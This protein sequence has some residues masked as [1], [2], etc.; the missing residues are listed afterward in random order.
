MLQNTDGRY[1]NR[2]VKNNINQ[3]QQEWEE[4]IFF[5]FQKMKTEFFPVAD[6]ETVTFNLN[7]L[8]NFQYMQMYALE[9][10]YNSF[11]DPEP[12]D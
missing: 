1:R 10:S 3:E 7:I 4:G 2:S 12:T 11:S 8:Y 9:W 5:G 6:S